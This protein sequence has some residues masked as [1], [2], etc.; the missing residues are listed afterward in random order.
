MVR[1]DQRCERIS[2]AD[3]SAIRTNSFVTSD[4]PGND[5]LISG[6]PGR[7]SSDFVEPTPCPQEAGSTRREIF[8]LHNCLHAL[9]NLGFG[10]HPLGPQF[11]EPSDAIE[12][13]AFE[14]ALAVG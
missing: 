11:V 14:A 7:G 2:E 10:Q 9:A 3:E 12:V 5:K 6:E 8:L 13:L 1:A 4:V